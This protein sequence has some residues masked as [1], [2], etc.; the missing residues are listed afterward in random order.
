VKLD[1]TAHPATCDPGLKGRHMR[2]LSTVAI[3]NFWEI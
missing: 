2:R 3:N 1:L